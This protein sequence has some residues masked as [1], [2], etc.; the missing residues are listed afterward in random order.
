M[1]S[2]QSDKATTPKIAYNL[3]GAPLRDIVANYCFNI[4]TV[5]GAMVWPIYLAVFVATFEGIGGIT[6]IAAI[7]AI[8]VTWVAGHR[9]D[10]GQD[11]AV[12]REGIIVSSIIDIVRILVTSQFWIAVV[13]SG[14][15]A[16]L[17]YFQNAWTSVY[18]HHAK[19]KG[20][21]YIM[22][23]EIACDL[24]YV[25]LWSILLVVLLASSSK[26]FFVVAFVVA[27]IA[28]LGCLLITKQ[29]TLESDLPR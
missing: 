29:G 18:Y 9:G 5:V 22:S 25:T 10:K 27:A 11:R 4:E 21:Q 6:A 28:A 26:A 19:Q 1:K 12:L 17:A 24:A 23:M 16:S 20:L 14:Y 7:V 15:K 13:S 2:I 8:V 3:R